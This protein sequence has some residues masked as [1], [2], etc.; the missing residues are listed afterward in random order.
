L[1]YTYGLLQPACVFSEPF[2]CSMLNAYRFV[3]AASGGGASPHEDLL[4]GRRHSERIDDGGAFAQANVPEPTRATSGPG[5]IYQSTRAGIAVDNAGHTRRTAG[6]FK[7][8][9]CLTSGD[10]RLICKI[11]IRTTGPA[12]TIEK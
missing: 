1:A 11:E 5:G 10:R 3:T 2:G 7:T 8:T 4:D 9:Q 12:T 6:T